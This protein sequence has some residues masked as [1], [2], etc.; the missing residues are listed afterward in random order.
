[1]ILA[2]AGIAYFSLR[3][4]RSDPAPDTTADAGKKTAGHGETTNETD[5]KKPDG[6]A[7]PPVVA[8]GAEAE[9][10][11]RKGADRGD[12][13]AQFQLGLAYHEGK[14]GVK[15]DMATA[16][17]WFKP[18][19][20]Q[21]HT[22]ASA[23]L[24][25]HYF[26]GKGIE[27]DLARAVQFSTFASDHGSAWAP[28]TLGEIYRGGGPGQPKD[29]KKAREYFQ[30]AVDRGDA[31]AHYSLGECFASGIGGPRNL[32]AAKKW[33]AKG[34]ALG[35]ERSKAALDSATTRTGNSEA[36]RLWLKDALAGDPEAQFQLGWF[37][38]FGGKGLTPNEP[39]GFAWYLKAAT[40]GHAQAMSQAGWCYRNGR[41]VER[42]LPESVRLL[43][44]AANLGSS[45][46][47]QNLGWS[48][49]T[50][51]GVPQSF[52]K[53]AELYEK[54]AK[55]NDAWGRFLLGN[56]YADGKGKPIDHKKAVELWELAAPDLPDAKKALE[57]YRAAGNKIE[58]TAVR[59]FRADAEKGNTDAQVRLGYAYLYGTEGV[60][61]DY[62]EAVKWLQ[63]AADH[64]SGEAFAQLGFC[65]LNGFGV[66]LNKAKGLDHYLRGA[67]KGSALGINGAA[68]CYTTG[69][70]TAKDETKALEWYRKGADA[71]DSVSQYEAGVRL[72]EG[73]GGPKDRDAG[74]KY[75]TK[76]A[77]QGN[78]D[79][80]K[81]LESLKP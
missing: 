60:T 40:N 61:K 49:E 31:Q 71:G 20:A 81:V 41:G 8:A 78:A 64:D 29:E 73:R 35:D 27:R 19:A 17:R 53:A 70:G 14:H 38:F 58:P 36:E 28:R 37:H 68:W 3:D 59:L 32:A 18:A 11:W 13:D 5:G 54:A 76:S 42:N 51:Q 24:G 67:N 48:Y 39:E 43:T 15:Q 44:K 23:Y 74:V 75:L 57:A 69:Q 21:G 80:K 6:I 34:A 9:L 77:A 65:Y 63:I 26:H 50:G 66:P 10:L 33:W 47:Q 55:Q 16:A 4:K 7:D 45:H 25:W 62:K 2:G 56:C 79:A 22:D 12:K 52:D 30:L 1:M 46:A 72:L